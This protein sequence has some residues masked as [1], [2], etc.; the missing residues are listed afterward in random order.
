MLRSLS[1]SSCITSAWLY[2]S[3]SVAEI[4]ARAE[5]AKCSPLELVEQIHDS[6]IP[7]IKPPIKRKIG[8]FVTTIRSLRKYDSEVEPPSWS[9]SFWAHLVGL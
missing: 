1:S 7:D 3:Q 4:V 8:S 9:D 6:K 5:K 2:I